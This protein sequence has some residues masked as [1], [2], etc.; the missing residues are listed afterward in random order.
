MAASIY[1]THTDVSAK[2]RQAVRTTHLI[3]QPARPWKMLLIYRPPGI[4]HSHPT[5]RKPRPSP[6]LH[7]RRNA[8]HRRTRT[9][10]SKR[11]D[12]GRDVKFMTRWVCQ[13]VREV[14]KELSRLKTR[15][16]IGRGSF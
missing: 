4:D 11:R 3:L 8:L 10:R 9:E 12:D 6:T 14:E 5:L 15:R 1:Q 13:E 7:I 16:G 2:F